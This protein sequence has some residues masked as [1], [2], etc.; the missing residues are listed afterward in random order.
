MRLMAANDRLIWIDT[1]TTGLE[2]AEGLILEIGIVVT[3]LD[4]RYQDSFHRVLW[5]SPGYDKY[6]TE[7]TL[8]ELV[9]T[10]HTSSGLI[11]EAVEGGV[12]PTSVQEDLSE[13][14]NDLMVDRTEPMCGSSI[15]FDRNWL[16]YHMT[17]IA[18]LF[19]YRNID[20][21]TIKELCRRYNPVIY[22][23]LD[24][25]TQPQKLHRVIPDIDDT[26]N[27]FRF[28]RDNFLFDAVSGEWAE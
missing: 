11:T 27:E 6:V 14:L 19:S 21:S 13:W 28:Y 25:V 22:G 12:D 8:G 18:D 9:W 3:D 26:I 20:I 16:E 5:S 2:P 17:D 7:A 4:L 10:M 23:R 24:E 15:Q 1:E